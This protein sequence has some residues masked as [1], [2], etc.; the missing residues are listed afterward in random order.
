MHFQNIESRTGKESGGEA[1]PELF[2]SHGKPISGEQ[3]SP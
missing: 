3:L 1:A 2:G